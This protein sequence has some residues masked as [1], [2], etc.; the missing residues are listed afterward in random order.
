[1]SAGLLAIAGIVLSLV[2]APTL[3]G[4]LALSL[5][6]MFLMSALTTFVRPPPV[7]PE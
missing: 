6:I 5:M 3:V 4:G 1:M 2:F 7:E